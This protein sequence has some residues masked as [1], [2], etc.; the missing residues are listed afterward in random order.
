MKKSIIIF[1]LYLFLLHNPVIPEAVKNPDKSAVS[2]RE[3]RV[4]LVREEGNLF[5]VTKSLTHN[6]Y[7]LMPVKG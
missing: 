7:F 2:F 6:F 5:T 3:A 1:I 4:Y